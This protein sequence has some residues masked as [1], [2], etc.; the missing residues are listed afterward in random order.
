[1]AQFV[2]ERQASALAAG[3]V[4]PVVTVLFV[5]DLVSSFR[6]NQNSVENQP[7]LVSDHCRS[8]LPAVEVQSVDRQRVV[9]SGHRD[10]HEVVVH[11]HHDHHAHAIVVRRHRDHRLRAVVV[12]VALEHPSALQQM[13][14]LPALMVE[15]RVH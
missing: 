7:E 15:P 9:V 14:H 5:H 1:M 8:N 6:S 4:D 2:V 10:H 3:L 11:Y 12:Q 13:N